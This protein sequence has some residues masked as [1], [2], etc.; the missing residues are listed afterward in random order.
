MIQTTENARPPSAVQNTRAGSAAL[1]NSLIQA[2]VAACV[3][4]AAALWAI[5][6]LLARPSVS[7]LQGPT[8]GTAVALCAAT[9]LILLSLSAW[10][11]VTRRG[12]SKAGHSWSSQ[13]P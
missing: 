12:T 10:G 9:G 2:A 11:L 8:A 3:F 1:S 7:W 4:A 13:P 5:T 6:L